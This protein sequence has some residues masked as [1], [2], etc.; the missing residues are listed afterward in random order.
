MEEGAIRKGLVA[1][2]VAASALVAACGS[3]GAREAPGGC[4]QRD[5][6]SRD[7]TAV[8]LSCGRGERRSVAVVLEAAGQT[9]ETLA[10]LREHNARASFVVT[11]LWAEAHPDLLNA[12]AAE[13]HQIINGS[14]SGASFT[15]A[16]TATAPLTSSERASE[17]SR[18]E[19]TVFRMSSRSTRPFFA[20]PYG[21]YDASVLG[22]AADA[23]YAFVVAGVHVDAGEALGETAAPGAVIHITDRVDLVAAIA[24]L[25]DAGYAFETVANIVE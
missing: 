11:G 3:E 8:A 9:R 10:S 19:T 25:R 13:G 7:T 5:L 15:G 17:L 1:T 14:Y 18:T 4:A 16:S 6:A 23:G 20:P 24:M 12:I 2:V 21:D 22:D